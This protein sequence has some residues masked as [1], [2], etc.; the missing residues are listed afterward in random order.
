MKEQDLL[1]KINELFRLAA[2]TFKESPDKAN[3]Y[4]T[5]ARRIAMKKRLKIPSTL[6]KKF[7]KNCYSYL[8][9]NINV[10]IRT[11]QGKLIYYCL[12]CKKYM[13]FPYKTFK[14]P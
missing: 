3:K 8:K 5:K 4:V 6:Q 10:R 7:C 9:P 2:Q 13:R 11:R 14:R 1:K 12:K